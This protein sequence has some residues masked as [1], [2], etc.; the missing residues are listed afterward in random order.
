MKYLLPL[1]FV[2][3]G[4]YTNAQTNTA[5]PEGAVSYVTSQN[6]YVRYASTEHLK[7]GDT[8]FVDQ[9]GKMMPVLTI[10]SLSSISAVCKPLGEYTGVEGDKLI[11][12]SVQ[13]A[14][15]VAEESQVKDKQP[16]QEIPLVEENKK[17]ETQ[18]PAIKQ[19]IS[20]RVGVSSYLNFSD[21]PGGNSQRMRYTFSL[22]ARNIND[23]KLS[24]ESYF[25]FVHRSGEWDEIK[26]DIFNGLKIYS[27]ALNYQ[28]SENY[29]LWLGRKINPRLSSVGAIDGLQYEMGWGAF[30]IGLVAGSR[31]D[32]LNYSFNLNLL[33]FGGYLGHEF[34]KE[35]GMA[36]TT[37]AIMEQENAGATDRRF[38]YIQHVNTLISNLYF[39]GSAEFDLYKK[40]NEKKSNTFNLSNLYLSLRYRI[41][42]PLSVTVSYSNRE[43]VVYY[44][45]YDRDFI[46]RLLDTDGTQGYLLQVNYRAGRNVFTGVKTGYR[47][48]LQDPLPTKNL[49]AFVTLSRLP[50][51]NSSV[52]LSATFL[53]TAYLSGKIFSIGMNKELIPARLDGGIGYRYVQYDFSHSE[54]ALNQNMAELILTWR[55]MQK[56]F[57]SLNFEGTF[58]DDYSY[59]RVYINLTQRF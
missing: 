24:L 48:R 58:D 54:S 53:E 20:G 57:G 21:S 45:T 39:F 15:T 17:T 2:I 1:L 30:T 9:D 6:V 42:K 28:F 4:L 23:S 10:S 25:S 36:Q 43:N 59:Q 12:R 41:I 40:V 47:F 44:A 32:N 50:V 49:Y 34:R 46:E 19:K 5:V 14:E 3:M 55:I 31:P 18:A 29:R 11:S 35:K 13:S 52:S 7:P 26:D 37:L 38:A 51:I 33:Q 16:G 27:L 22:N 8:L 56:L